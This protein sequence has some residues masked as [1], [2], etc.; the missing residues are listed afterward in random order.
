MPKP[1]RLEVSTTFGVT[2]SVTIHAYSTSS[3]VHTIHYVAISRREE[4]SLDVWS[5]AIGEQILASRVGVSGVASR[6]NLTRSDS[7]WST[8]ICGLA[9]DMPL[10]IFVCPE[11]R[12]ENRSFFGAVQSKIV[13]TA[14]IPPV[15]LSYSASPRISTSSDI[16]IHVEIMPKDR[17]N[18]NVYWVAVLNSDKDIDLK[19]SEIVSA[20][21]SDIV[22]SG[23]LNNT[24]SNVYSSIIS[25]HDVMFPPSL[26]RDFRVFERSDDDKTVEKNNKDEKKL[27]VPPTFNI[28]VAAE[29]YPTRSATTRDVTIP[30]IPVQVFGAAPKW[31]SLDVKPEIS[32]SDILQISVALDCPSL[33]FYIAIESTHHE[34]VDSVLEGKTS[35]DEIGRLLRDLVE[36]TNELSDNISRSDSVS[37]DD[38]KNSIKTFNITYLE[39]CTSYDVFIVPDVRGPARVF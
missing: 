31:I 38:E 24:Q 35:D 27:R 17:T 4:K 5:P 34:L 26:K 37:F 11:I 13:R 20:S 2:R 14:E 12:H 3:N 15:V 25:L 21:H 16:E 22:A 6:G 29:A 30:F 18:P 33:L 7:D 10:E 36:K 28:Y 39:P 8:S 9:T 1:L 19:A 23:T 32:Q